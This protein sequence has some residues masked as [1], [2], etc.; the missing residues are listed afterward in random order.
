MATDEE[1][2]D[3][4]GCPSP[5]EMLKQHTALLE[6]EIAELNQQ[7]RA[8][9]ENT[10]KLVAI[11]AKTEADRDSACATLRRSKFAAPKG[12]RPQTRVLAEGHSQRR[13]APADTSRC[14]VVP[15]AQK[16]HTF[17]ADAEVFQNPQTLERW[18]GNGPIRKTMQVRQAC[19]IGVRIRPDRP[20][21]Q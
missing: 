17:L 12:A 6:N 9:R 5:E 15:K 21:P 7:I 8:T 18:A 13:S 10:F 4:L 11:L 20:T 19:D 1:D 14:A 16:L 3:F 2:F